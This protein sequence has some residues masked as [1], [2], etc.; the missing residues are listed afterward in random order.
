MDSKL[1]RLA[2]L[3]KAPAGGASPAGG[4]LQQ[5][6]VKLKAQVK[7]GEDALKAE[8]E[9]VKQLQQQLT[10]QKQVREM[11]VLKLTDFR[12][13]QL[14][15]SLSLQGISNGTAGADDVQS[16]SDSRFRGLRLAF[17]VSLV[18]GHPLRVHCALSPPSHFPCFCCIRACR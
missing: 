10:Q 1:S 17:F 13:D 9:Q 5:Q 11:T 12:F 16:V 3:E 8:Q 18:G 4:N 2:E 15:F 7:F 14:K 6:I